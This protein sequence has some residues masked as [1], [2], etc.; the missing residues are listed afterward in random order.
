VAKKSRAMIRYT[1][2][3]TETQPTPAPFKATEN[4]PDRAAYSR[5]RLANATMDLFRNFAEKHSIGNDK[6]IT[7]LIEAY[8]QQ[9]QY[10]YSS[11]SGHLIAALHALDADVARLCSLNMRM[12]EYLVLL[13]RS[14]YQALATYIDQLASKA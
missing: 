12:I 8:E 1:N 7:S 3:S 11:E 10:R 9:T 6:A 13:Q 4:D 14:D 5:I 2:M